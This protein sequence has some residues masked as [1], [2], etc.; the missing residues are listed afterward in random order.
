VTVSLSETATLN[1]AIANA[2][3][4]PQSIRSR[5]FEKYA[6]AGKKDGTG[7][8]TYG[9]RLIAETHG[10]TIAMT[11]SET[12]GTVVSIA[13]PKPR[14]PAARADQADQA[15]AQPEQS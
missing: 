13:F 10:A 3:A 15:Q 2:G 6:T 11:T 8:G 9:A 12:R 1:V 4:V 5:F 7:L 14:H